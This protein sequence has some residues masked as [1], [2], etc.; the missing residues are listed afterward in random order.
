MLDT[1][2]TIPS[3]EKAVKCIVTVAAVK[4]EEKPQIIYSEDKPAKKSIT[5]KKKTTNKGEIA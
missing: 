4:G 5:I 2:F 1:M 3:E